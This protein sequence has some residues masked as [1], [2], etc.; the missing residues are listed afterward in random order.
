MTT[1]YQD[2]SCPPL[3]LPQTSRATMTGWI[4]SK[5]YAIL[6][7]VILPC[8]NFSYQ[9][10]QHLDRRYYIVI[11][12]AVLCYAM[13]CYAMLCYAVISYYRTAHQNSLFV[14]HKSK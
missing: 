9:Y 7:S 14:S 1:P 10:E 3:G 8:G 6:S 11:S 2:G 12:Y 5:E 13:L 4:R